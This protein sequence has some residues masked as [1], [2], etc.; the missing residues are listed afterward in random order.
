MIHELV[1]NN[2]PIMNE[3]ESERIKIMHL[4]NGFGLKCFA[5]KTQEEEN[6]GFSPN[7][8]MFNEKTKSFYKYEY[9]QRSIDTFSYDDFIVYFGNQKSELTFAFYREKLYFDNN[10]LVVN[11]HVFSNNILSRHLK[12]MSEYDFG[13]KIPKIY[14]N[15]ENIK[16]SKNIITICKLV[17]LGK[18]CSLCDG[19]YDLFLKFP[20]VFRQLNPESYLSRKLSSYE[21][22][23]NS[24]SSNPDEI[25]NAE[26][27]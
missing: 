7:H 2:L 16:Y 11:G 15:I 4:C 14:E 3:D 8:V 25:I 17:Y 12:K 21:R 6:M 9:Q 19:E 27:S 20:V 10:C 22:G 23:I 26:I 24:H 18:V 5:T 1:K 13:G